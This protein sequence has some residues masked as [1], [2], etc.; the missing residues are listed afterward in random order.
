M[1]WPPIFFYYESRKFS[2]KSHFKLE[3][4]QHWLSLCTK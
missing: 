1:K 3:S 4:P 2:R